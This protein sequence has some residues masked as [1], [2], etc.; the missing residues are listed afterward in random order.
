MNQLLAPSSRVAFAALTHDL[1][2]FAERA[3]LTDARLDAHITDYCKWHETGGGK[4]YHSHKHAAF[5]ALCLDVV[6]Q[7]AP[8]LI[9][10][11]VT[12]FASRQDG[13]EADITDS[14]IN[15][16]AMH[17]RPETLLQWIIA[18]ADRVASG[19][20]RDEFD[21]YNDAEDKTDT[22]HNHFQARQLTLFEQVRLTDEKQHT[23][24]AS[25]DY[26]Y[27]LKALSPENLFPVKRVGYESE[28]DAPAQKEYRAL[29]E[30]FL[31]ALK[32]DIPASHRQQWPLW[33]DHFDTLWQT[34]THAIPAA[35]AFN[36]KPEVSLYDH[37]KA[38]AAFAVALWRW[39]IAQEGLSDADAIRQHKD[40]ADW[41]EKKFLLVQGDFFGIQDFIFS[42]GAETNRHAAKLLRG[43]SF[44]VSLFTELA[45]LKVLEACELPSTSQIINA[46]GKFLIVAPNTAEVREKL[47]MVRRELN[48][49][50]LENTFG[51][52]GLGLVEKSASCS[53][54]LQDRFKDLMK[55]LFADLETAKLSR[56]ALTDDAPRVFEVEYPQGVC[57]YNTRLPA[58]VQGSAPLSR[59]QIAIGKALAHKDRL[60]VVRDESE[61]RKGSVTPLEIPVFGYRIGFTEGE[62]ETGKFGALAQSGELVRCWDFSLPENLTDTLWHGYARRYINA[63]V[64]VFGEH[65]H[66][67]SDK[68]QGVEADEDCRPGNPKTFNHLACEDRQP[69]EHDHWIGQVALATL[70]GDVDN[71]G[72]I[73]QKGLKQNTFAKMAALSRQ[74]NA[75]FAVWLPAYCKEKYPN[76]YTVFAGGDDFFLV[77]PW[78][79]TQKLA[80]EMAEHFKAFVAENPEI[81]FSAGI[82]TTKPGHPVHALAEQAETA[83]EK[84]KGYEEDGQK[85]K[86]ALSL[87]GEIVPWKDWPT[88]ARLED[89]VR[90]LADD[91]KLS[92]GYVY[93]LLSL[94]DLAADKTRQE[95]AMWRS[96]FTYRTCRY[97]VDKLRDKDARSVALARLATTFGENGIAV[98]KSR[99]RIPLFNFFYSKRKG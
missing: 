68:Y 96:R 5:T 40:R 3:G 12:P 17:H 83:L 22:G 2:K 51:L 88:L 89:E 28:Q 38:T 73:F 48:Q 43:R 50:F 46:A 37:S 97:V 58:D 14:L 91:Y 21:R 79:S 13:T 78:Q 99:F 74:M 15:A 36:V 98:Q 6:E 66:L 16:A 85:H 65:D 10:G 67:T 76:T 87:Y 60:L 33:L 24:A 71:L 82:I 18:T 41:N 62:E 64:P 4:G 9:R 52:A 53:D 69:D 34:F 49:W 7:S 42:E 61:L 72:Q 23:T 55:G 59:D 93:G 19:F 35:T 81:H 25:L 44:Q 95:S 54:F 11:D 90:Q 31:L 86:N 77:G 84:A 1:G 20:E 63:Y 30:A 57:A 27:P 56:F 92:T 26:R 94:I 75:F 29:W 39:H 70:K 45:A 32:D 8:D 80:A 47:A